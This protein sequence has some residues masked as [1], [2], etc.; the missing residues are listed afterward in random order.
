MFRRSTS[1]AAA[2]HVALLRRRSRRSSRPGSA[3][4]TSSS[5]PTSPPSSRR[6]AAGTYLTPAFST[7][8]IVF[9]FVRRGLLEPNVERVCGLLRLR[10]DAM[11]AALE[12]ELPEASWSTP[13]RRLLPVARAAGGR[14]TR[15]R[16]SPRASEA[17]VTF[18]AGGDFFAQ[19][20]GRSGRG[21][22]GVQLRLTG[23]DRGGRRA[24]SR[25]PARRRRLGG[26]DLQLGPN[27]VGE[28][29][30]RRAE[31]PAAARARRSCTAGTSGTARRAG[32]RRA[33]LGGNSNLHSVL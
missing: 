23:R 25:R 31:R 32:A 29:A 7:Q 13:G 1:W 33:R 6:S 18:V 24:A 12:R 26:S 15:G 28:W 11:L 21:A 5:R 22:A 9:E 30:R 8:A 14:R 16:R 3:S 2:T 17:G 27:D 4:A 20:G 19:P 10:R